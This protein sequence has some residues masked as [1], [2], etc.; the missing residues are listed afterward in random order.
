MEGLLCDP[1]SLN[2]WTVSDAEEMHS[3]DEVVLKDMLKILDGIEPRRNW[4]S[5]SAFGIEKTRIIVPF[6]EAVARR[7][8]VLLIVMQ[9]RGV[10]C[11]VTTFTASS[12]EALNRST[13]P[14]VGGI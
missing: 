5:L 6:S 8:P 11:A 12:L 9:D 2:M 4:Y 3:S 7:V 14:L 13:S 1:P 10:L